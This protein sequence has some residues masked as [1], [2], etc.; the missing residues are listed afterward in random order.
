M[1]I[2]AF[3]YLS[4]LLRLGHAEQVLQ[5]QLSL[6]TFAAPYTTKSKEGKEVPYHVQSKENCSNLF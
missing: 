6:T 3:N 5:I 2:Q 1:H 4:N